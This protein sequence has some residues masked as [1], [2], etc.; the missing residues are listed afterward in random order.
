MGESVVFAVKEVHKSRF[1]DFKLISAAEAEVP[2]KPGAVCA[3]CEDGVRTRHL[4]RSLQGEAQHRL[5]VLR[6]GILCARLFP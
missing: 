2:A 4:S 5:R 3:G 1:Y 6:G